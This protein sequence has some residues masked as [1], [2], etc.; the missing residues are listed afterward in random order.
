MADAGWKHEIEA[1]VYAGERLSRADGE[2][3][4][5]CDELAWLGSCSTST[6][7]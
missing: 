1:K 7:T 3:L 4:Y 2:A 5:A 6:G